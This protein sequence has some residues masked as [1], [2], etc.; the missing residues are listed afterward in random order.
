MADYTPS[1][2]G[3]ENDAT[4]SRALERAIFLEM[5]GGEVLEAFDTEQVT[6]G[7]HFFKHIDAGKS[8]QFPQ[9]W[10]ADG[11]YHV[12]GQA[13]AGGVIE[14]QQRTVTIEDLYVAH[15]FIDKHDAAMNHWDARQPYVHQL[16]EKLANEKDTNVFRAIA[17][18]A[19]ASHPFDSNFDGTELG[20][21]DLDTTAGAKAVVY[22]AAQ[23]LDE[24]RAPASDRMLACLPSMWYLLLED[25]EFINRDFAGEGSKARA[26]IPFAADLEVLKSNNIPVADD[27]S[28]VGVPVALQ[29]DYLTTRGVIWHK[30][31]VG[32]VE[33]MSLVVESGYEI[34][35]KGTLHTAEYALGTDYL[36]TEACIWLTSI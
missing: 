3:A 17:Q 27:T 14:N 8:A 7:K 31:A 9:T 28:T 10:K 22:D 12:A 13:L 21:E 1:R 35:Y 29:S 15:V 18:G 33:L 36:R 6:K 4:G 26:T 34:R 5:F 24:N 16:A 30:S 11:G 20:G 19:N 2:L 23:T 25:G 32:V